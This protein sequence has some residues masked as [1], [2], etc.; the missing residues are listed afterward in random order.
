[1]ALHFECTH[2]CARIGLDTADIVR[3]GD[4]SPTEC[5]SQDLPTI[6]R[7]CASLNVH[8]RFDAWTLFLRGPTNLLLEV[9]LNDPTALV[10]ETEGVLTY[11]LK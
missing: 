11:R 10:G 9:A 8:V 4:F 2:S 1:M 7:F 5:D 6:R 3:E